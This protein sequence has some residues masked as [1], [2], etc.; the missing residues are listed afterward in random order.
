MTSDKRKRAQ[1]LAHCQQI[2][3]D[4]GIDPREF[5]QTRSRQQRRDHKTEQLCQQVAETLGL[6]FASEFPDDLLQSLQVIS[7]TPAPHAGQLLVLVCG[8]PPK[9]YSPTAILQRLHQV[10]GHLRWLVTAAI[11]RKRAPK[12]LFQIGNDQGQHHHEV[13]A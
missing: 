1:M 5:F 8:V 11:T 3:P 2:H 4:D 10:E 12:L 7:V 13:Q 6:V 9:A